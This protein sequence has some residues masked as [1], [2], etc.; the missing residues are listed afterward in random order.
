VTDYIC[1]RCNSD[2]RLR[3]AKVDSEG[4]RFCLNC[5]GPRCPFDGC[6]VRWRD[7]DD[8]LCREHGRDDAELAA[9]AEL[10]GIG[11]R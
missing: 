5:T 9:L 2:L 4:R 1:A 8:R 10:F 6:A 3:P 7:G 11:E